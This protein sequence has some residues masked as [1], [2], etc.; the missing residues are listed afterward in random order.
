MQVHRRLL[1]GDARQKCRTFKVLY[2]C[3]ESLNLILVF[4]NNA[5]KTLMRKALLSTLCTLLSLPSAI[6]ARKFALHVDLHHAPLG[7]ELGSQ[8]V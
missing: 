6:S 8:R 1:A 7:F 3:L 2:F 5:W 4:L